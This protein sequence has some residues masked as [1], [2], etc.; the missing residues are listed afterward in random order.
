MILN[1]RYR[2]LLGQ[3]L[4]EVVIAL[5]IVVAL[6]TALI[7]AGLI[8]QR[9]SRTAQ[10]NSQATRLAQQNIEQIRIFRD[11]QGFSAIS[12]GSCFTID[13]SS[14]D[15]AIWTLSTAMCPTG[16]SLILG[17]IQF[18]RRISIS[19]DGSD[20]KIIEVTVSW[21]D[22]GGVQ[23]VKNETILGDWE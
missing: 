21:E 22:S 13:A 23:V 7:T 16:E 10:Y 5:G 12:D 2:L 3:S 14:P 20:K 9:S 18:N 11:R 17:N 19:P 4:I 15:P 8:T 6:S 1:N